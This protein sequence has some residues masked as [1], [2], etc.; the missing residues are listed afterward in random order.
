MWTTI[1]VVVVV[2]LFLDFLFSFLKNNTTKTAKKSPMLFT[3][4]D[5][6]KNS[7]LVTKG[8]PNSNKHASQ[9]IEQHK[10][11]VNNSNTNDMVVPAGAAG[12]NPVVVDIMAPGQLRT[13]IEVENIQRVVG[14]VVQRTWVPCRKETHTTTF[15]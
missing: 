8:S 6:K 3:M 12:Q 13:T 1:G 5:V 14:N 15:E 7:N 2:F 9:K 4:I 10:T 11:V